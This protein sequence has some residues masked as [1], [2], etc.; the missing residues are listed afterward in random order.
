[1]FCRDWVTPKMKR[2]GKLTTLQ[3]VENALRDKLHYAFGGVLFTS[4]IC[5]FLSQ[6]RLLSFTQTYRR[7]KN[8][9]GEEVAV[10]PKVKK[11]TQEVRIQFTHC[12]V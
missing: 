7:A 11:L 10:H 6:T 3:R 4:F 1:M 12:G 9:A 2:F 5:G 8:R